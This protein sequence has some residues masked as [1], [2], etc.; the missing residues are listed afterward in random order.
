[1]LH[2]RDD[3][4]VS[5]KTVEGCSSIVPGEHISPDVECFLNSPNAPRTICKFEFCNICHLQFMRESPEISN[6]FFAA[7][8]HVKLNDDDDGYGGDGGKSHKDCNRQR[9]PLLGR[10]RPKL[11]VVQQDANILSANQ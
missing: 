4:T 7:S 5:L 10:T 1:M 6:L 9:D 3:L 11:H 8:R 2:D